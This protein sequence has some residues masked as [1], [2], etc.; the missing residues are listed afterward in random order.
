MQSINFDKMKR[1]I[2]L[3]SAILSF[4]SIGLIILAHYTT[5]DNDREIC[6]SLLSSLWG[7]IIAGLIASFLFSCIRMYWKAPEFQISDKIAERYNRFTFKILNKTKHGIGNIDVNISYVTT[8]NGYYDARPQ[9]FAYLSSKKGRPEVEIMLSGT[10]RRI[11]DGEFTKE[12]QDTVMEFF[13][14]NNGSWIE[15]VIT[16]D[17][18]HRIL[19]VIKR[20]KFIQ[21]T[22]D[23]VVINSFFR[24]GEIKP[25]KYPNENNNEYVNLE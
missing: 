15:I 10:K 3:L 17:D 18:Y 1:K 24:P 7:G 9:K 23:D 20:H 2:L 14:D 16:Y 8:N 21:Y 12:K 4:I 11:I 5:N 6:L 19:G 13:K 25:T 22:S